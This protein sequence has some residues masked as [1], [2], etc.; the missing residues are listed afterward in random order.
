MASS[1]E[2]TMIWLPLDDGWGKTTW[3]GWIPH[4]SCV[5]ESWAK[6]HP[7]SLTGLSLLHMQIDTYLIETYV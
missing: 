4:Q 2:E 5:T 6:Y 1:E 7:G 3:L